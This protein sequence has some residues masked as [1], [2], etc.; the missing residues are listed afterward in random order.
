MTQLIWILLPNQNHHLILNLSWRWSIEVK[1][2][3]LCGLFRFSIIS[4]KRHW[5]TAN[6]PIS[7]LLFG[8][9]SVWRTSW[10]TSFPALVQLHI[11]TDSFQQF[12]YSVYLCVFCNQRSFSFS[13][14]GRCQSQRVVILV[15]GPLSNRQDESCSWWL[16]DIYSN[17]FYSWSIWRAQSFCRTSRMSSCSAAVKQEPTP[18]RAE[19]GH[20]RSLLHTCFFLGAINHKR[21]WPF[22][23]DLSHICRK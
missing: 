4:Q 20:R 9:Q 11:D 21:N 22:T 18:P 10:S 15:Q 1:W 23:G 5:Q 2:M 3:S 7:C 14:L 6:S 13:P 17:V 16:C 12:H 19:R 8:G